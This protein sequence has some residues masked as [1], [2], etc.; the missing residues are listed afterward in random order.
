MEGTIKG[1]ATLDAGAAVLWHFI[2]KERNALAAAMERL[3]S[4]E[5]TAG[6]SVLNK[7]RFLAK[8]FIVVV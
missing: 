7:T 1:K 4:S 3:L 8:L 2:P 5:A 6:R